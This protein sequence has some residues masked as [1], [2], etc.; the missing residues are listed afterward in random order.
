MKNDDLETVKLI[1]ATVSD[2][3]IQVDRPAGVTDE[4]WMR[5]ANVL[6]RAFGIGVKIWN[7]MR[8][9][10]PEGKLDKEKLN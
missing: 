5:A 7:A 3:G 6:C 4:E 8:I 10:N 1:K 2:L 9:E